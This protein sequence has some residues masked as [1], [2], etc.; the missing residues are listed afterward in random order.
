MVDCIFNNRL[1]DKSWNFY[2]LYLFGY[3]NIENKSII[4][5]YGN[6]RKILFDDM[7]FIG[8]RNYFTAFYAVPHNLRQRIDNLDN[9]V[10]LQQQAV[11]FDTV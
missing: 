8:K 10:A 3:I 6:N 11:T 2:L 9:F 4:K 5:A 7:E 1:E